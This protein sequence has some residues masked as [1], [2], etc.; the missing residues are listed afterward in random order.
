MLFSRFGLQSKIIIILSVAVVSV[1]A[2]STYLAML[3]TRQPV[4]EAIYRKVLSQALATAHQLDAQE[5]GNGI[6]L[7]GRLREVQRD[8]KGVEQCDVRAH[9]PAHSLVATT[10]AAG[11]HLELDA[12]PGI[13]HY[14]EFESAGEDQIS[15]E[16]PDGRDW[17]VSTPIRGREGG[18]IGCLQL[19][20][21]KKTSNVIIDGLVWR[22][23]I[24]MLASLVAVMLAVHVFF[25]YNVRRPVKDMVEVMEAAE[26]GALQVRAH[27]E[28][29]EKA[30]DEIARLAC[31]LNRML[32]RMENFNAE[33][34]GK[35]NEATGEL[36]RRNEELT[37][38]NEELFDTQ[39]TLARSERLAVAGQLAAS[40]AHEIGTPLN[41]IS[42]HVQLMAKRKTGD[43]TMDRRLQI[44][45]SQIEN[46]VRSVKQLLS[47]TRKFE[48]RPA[49]IDVRQVIEEVVLLSSP[50]LEL[51]KIRVRTDLPLRAPNIYA[52]AGYLQQVF[53]NL[54]NN[55]IDAMPGGGRLEI[56]VTTPAGSDGGDEPPA[57]KVEVEDTGEGIAPETL[58]HIFDPMFTTKRMGTGAGLGLAICKQIVQQHGGSIQASSQ[59]HRGTR[60]IITLPVDSRVQEETPAAALSHAS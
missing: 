20:V 5:L 47:W 32:S 52:D 10:D 14:N 45:D 44:I 28:D 36:A 7:L 6:N 57:I 37:R 58:K 27:C 19:R 46:I 16:T 12:T 1:A 54:I 3:L 25:L 11:P 39:K 41:S 21:S 23:L 51:R 34:A 60:F 4:E 38:I 31:H 35:V 13:E 24:L 2:V 42:G 50:V 22:N 53:L 30:R 9:D 56:R 8:F 48:L 49:M 40:L 43:K 55:S 29:E 15:I 33:L 26:G 59:V 17:I 18:S